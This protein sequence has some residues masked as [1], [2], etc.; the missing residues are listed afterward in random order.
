MAENRRE[1]VRIIS[2]NP[3]GVADIDDGSDRLVNVFSMQGVLLRSNVHQPD[4]TRGL[5]TGL[6]IVGGKKSLVR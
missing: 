1:K 2:G 3:S 4:A 5:L 6:Y